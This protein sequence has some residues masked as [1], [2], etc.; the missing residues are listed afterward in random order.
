MTLRHTKRLIG[1]KGGLRNAKPGA[2]GKLGAR[3]K[4]AGVFLPMWKQR[5]V[6]EKPT[7][8]DSE[9]VTQGGFESKQGSV[10]HA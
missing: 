1:L 5:I 3:V 6:G 2:W 7:V 10:R 8:C 4:C 9:C